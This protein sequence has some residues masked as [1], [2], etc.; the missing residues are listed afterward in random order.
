MPFSR[1]TWIAA[2][3]RRGLSQTSLAVAMGL[4]R[5]TVCNIERGRHVPSLDTLVAA[6]PVLKLTLTKLM[7]GESQ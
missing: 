1:A 6:A 2:R 7:N 3:R 4:H 5:I